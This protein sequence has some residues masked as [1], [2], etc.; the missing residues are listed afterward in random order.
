MFGGAIGNQAG[1]YRPVDFNPD[2]GNEL[3]VNPSFSHDKNIKPN[4]WWNGGASSSSNRGSPP[5]KWTSYS[6]MLLETNSYKS[7]GGTFMTTQNSKDRF[8]YDPE[9]TDLMNRGIALHGA[10]THFPEQT[11]Y[12]NND[13]DRQSPF[14]TVGLMAD[15]A[16]VPDSTLSNTNA[17][18]YYNRYDMVQHIGLGNSISSLKFGAYVK[19][20]DDDDFLSDQYIDTKCNFGGIYLKT[21]NS[22]GTTETVDFICISKNNSMNNKLFENKTLSSDEAMYNWSGLGYNWDW[23]GTY[24]IVTNLNRIMGN[25]SYYSSSDFRQYKRVEMTINNIP[26]GTNRLQF[27]LFF[28]ESTHHTN[29][30]N[31]NLTGSIRFIEPFVEKLN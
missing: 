26:S 13:M 19:V 5:Y 1:N 20:P 4:D 6:P 18:G 17:I 15:T 28:A 30:Q 12:P 23:N 25:G 21:Y 22:V 7:W 8:Y 24:Q 31:S 9:T 2:S 16:S 29:N 11:T 3:L 14:P 10:G 27:G